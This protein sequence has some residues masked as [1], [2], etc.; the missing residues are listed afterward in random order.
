[1]DR[2]SNLCKLSYGILIMLVMAS[3]CLNAQPKERTFSRPEYP[4]SMWYST[5]DALFEYKWMPMD[6]EVM[7]NAAFDIIQKRYNVERI[8]WRDANIE[9]VVRWDKERPFSYYTDAT[10]DWIKTN[11]E[12]RTTEFAEKAARARGMK[13]WGIFH[14]FDYGGRASTG[15]GWGIGP[16]HSYDPW[17][18]EHPEYCLWDRAG[19]TF[20]T[21]IIEYGY[22]EV[23]KEYVRRM[24]E[25]FKGPFSRYDGLFIYN[26]LEHQAVHF[27]DEYIYSDIACKEYKKQYGVDPRTE[28]FDLDKYYEIRGEY[29]TQFLRDLRPLFKKYNKKLA[30]VL[31]PVNLEWPMRW[32]RFDILHQGRVKWDWRTW[33]KEGLVDE[34]HVWGGVPAE[35]RYTAVQ[36]ILKV[37][38]DTPVKVTVVSGEFPESMQYLYSEGVRRLA[39]ASSRN[40]DGYAEKCPVSDLTSDDPL[41]VLSVV[42]QIR[43]RELDVPVEKITALL[44]HT[45]PMVRRQA[46]RVIGELQIQ[47]G[48]PAL[49]KRAVEETEST[50]KAMVIDSLGKINSP[51][52]VA[53]ITKGFS[54]LPTWS[55]RRA[56]IVALSRMGL[57]HYAQIVKAF[58]SD[59]P[60][61]RAMLMESIYDCENPDKNLVNYPLIWE[62]YNLAKKGV[63]DPSPKVRWQALYSISA[64][65]NSGAIDVCLEALDDPVD[66]VQNR[67]ATS[68]KLILQ[69]AFFTSA[70]KRQRLLD[71]LLEKYNEFG[72]N[73]KRTDADWGWRPIGDAIR[74]S[75]GTKGKNA[76]IN[77][78]N[79]KN[80]ELAKLTWQVLF[81]PEDMK[82]YPISREE[83]ESRYRYYPGRPDHI[84]CP[85][86]VLD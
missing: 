25:M 58:D 54:N 3:S 60:L 44:T 77:I 37:T 35:K 11:R 12:N 33:V 47:A 51:D 56:S 62:L 82:W 72:P 39:Y 28:P 84:A 53:A 75:F 34:L 68:I 4:V 41:S 30:M 52:S 8:L 10:N 16:F 61:L 83:M 14:L 79:G 76:L 31:N 7:I 2:T 26:Y 17:L 67:A 23:R 13:F 63:K 46:A 15:A 48:V 55:V 66:E 38:K 71:K 65:P 9:W 64:F 27:T 81:L 32:M 59:D 57:E 1:M 69:T 86:T 73:C 49:E 18:I 45:N 74:D 70:D 50:V 21:G 6:S 43:Q 78:L 42:R 29:I 85:S 5:G 22:P 19:I 36:E 20:L 24:E 80:T 40:E